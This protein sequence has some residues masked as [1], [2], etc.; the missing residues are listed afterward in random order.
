[1]LFTSETWQFI[2]RFCE[3]DGDKTYKFTGFDKATVEDKERIIR[4]DNSFYFNSGQHIISNI[5]DLKKSIGYKNMTYE[6]YCARVKECLEKG[7]SLYGI[8]W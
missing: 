3:T 7:I 6:E 1:M 4:F 8:D 2:G 5:D